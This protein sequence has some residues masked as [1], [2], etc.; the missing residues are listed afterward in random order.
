MNLHP[1]ISH[2]DALANQIFSARPAQIERMTEGVSTFVYQLVYPDEIFYL[3]ILPEEDASFAPE[4]AVHTRLRQ[5]QVKVPEVVYFEHCHES[6]HRSVMITTEI[7]G[8]PLSQSSSLSVKE[9]SSILVEAGRDL[10]Q[11]NSI[12]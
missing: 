12:A 1:D 9:L 4:V 6:L 7:K 8:Q 3:R 5:M 2:I 11:I 10:E